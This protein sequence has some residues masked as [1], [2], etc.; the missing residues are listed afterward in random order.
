[1]VMASIERVTTF[2][3]SDFGARGFGL[4]LVIDGVHFVAKILITLQK[5]AEKS[6]CGCGVLANSGNFCGFFGVLASRAFFFFEGFSGFAGARERDGGGEPILEKFQMIGELGCGGVLRV[7]G[8]GERFG[9]IGA[10]EIEEAAGFHVI[11]NGGTGGA[12]V[13]HSGGD[14]QNAPQAGKPD[15]NAEDQAEETQSIKLLA[16]REIHNGSARG[17][18]AAECLRGF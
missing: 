2:L 10:S 7:A 13:L 17:P 4:Q 16:D 6:S 11:A 1:M 18:G 14:L 3:A 15:G 5:I 8:S 12:D 9:N